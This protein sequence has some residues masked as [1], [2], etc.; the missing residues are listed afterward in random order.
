MA[1]PHMNDSREL[2]EV[3]IDCTSLLVPIGSVSVSVETK[4]FTQNAEEPLNGPFSYNYP[5][6]T[7]LFLF[8]REEASTGF[9][10]ASRKK[11]GKET[12]GETTRIMV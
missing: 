3:S 4:A 11:Q 9:S 1:H 2:S 5:G 7:E 10:W 8:E 12:K 6:E